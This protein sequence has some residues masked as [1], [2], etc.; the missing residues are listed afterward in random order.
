MK[1]RPL[2]LATVALGL[3]VLAA[4]TAHARSLELGPVVAS[5]DVDAGDEL[6][7]ELL[8]PLFSL[9]GL[10]GGMALSLRGRDT[11]IQL[12]GYSATPY[13]DAAG[14]SIGFGHF[15]KPGES[16][17]SITR[18]Q[19]LQLLAE[20]VHQA[21]NVVNTLVRVP[22]TQAQFDALVCFV[23]NIGAGAFRR[24]TLLR[25]LNAGNYAA[26]PSEMRRWRYETKPSGQKV[27]NAALVA[28]RE[29]EA[30]MFAA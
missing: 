3:G 6:L 17:T 2:V 13:R 1:V 14:W 19:A 10:M 4:R 11:L 18:D 27:E 9:G 8:A 29:T 7:D 26:V 12:E 16:F 24:S 21:A 20:D 15:I 30:A 25:E 28:R 5:D 22:L 23:Y